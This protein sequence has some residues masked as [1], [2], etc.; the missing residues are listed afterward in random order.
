MTQTQ[1]PT[2]REGLLGLRAASIWSTTANSPITLRKWYRRGGCVALLGIAGVV[3][4]DYGASA[5]P[6]PPFSN[7]L[8]LF[9]FFDLTLLGF[10]KGVFIFWVAAGMLLWLMNGVI[11]LGLTDAQKAT[12]RPAAPTSQTGPAPASEILD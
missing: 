10:F 6:F 5:I 12:A 7:N 9:P 11:W 8:P 3:F 1:Q 2:P 4:V